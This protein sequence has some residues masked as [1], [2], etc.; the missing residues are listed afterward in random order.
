MSSQESISALFKTNFRTD[1][2][3]D[4][5]E[6]LMFSFIGATCGLAG[7]AYI[8]FHRQIVQFFRK[9]KRISGFLQQN[10]FVYPIFVTL[11]ITTVT[12]PPFIGKYTAS[13][14]S[15]H[16]TIEHLFSNRTWSLGNQDLVSKKILDQWTTPDTNFHLHLVLYILMLFWTSAL[17]ST[18]PIPSGLFIP[19]LKMGA[20]YGRLLGELMHSAFPDGIKYGEYVHPASIVPGS[21]A[22]VGAAAFSGA[23]TH[24]I[25]T[26]V[27]LFEMTGQIVHIIP[28]ILGVLIANAVCQSLQPS[29]YDSIIEIKK[30]P[31]LPPIASSNSV[32]HKILVKDFMNT[33][34]AYVWKEKCT[35]ADLKLLLATHKKIISFPLVESQQSMKL[36]GSVPRPDLLKLLYLHLGRERRLQEVCRRNS[37]TLQPIGL[38]EIVQNVHQSAQIKKDINSA[39][40]TLNVVDDD[41]DDEDGDASR[42]KRDSVDRGIEFSGIGRLDECDVTSTSTPTSLNSNESLKT[43]DKS[44][45]SPNQ[46]KLHLPP[47]PTNAGDQNWPRD[48]TKA[49]L[50]VEASMPANY[51]STTVEL[52]QNTHSPSLIQGESL[53]IGAATTTNESINSKHENDA[54]DGDNIANANVDDDEDNDSNDSNDN[55]VGQSNIAKMIN[56]YNRG[57]SMDDEQLNK[58]IQ[59]IQNQLAAVNETPEIVIVLPIELSQ[60]IDRQFVQQDTT[61]QTEIS[62]SNSSLKPPKLSHGEFRASRPLS[63]VSELKPVSS[64]NHVHPPSSPSLSGRPTKSILKSSSTS[65]SFTNMYKRNISS[66]SFSSTI[67]NLDGKQVGSDQQHNN[68]NNPNNQISIMI[69]GG[70]NLTLGDQTNPP[71]LAPARQRRKVRLP[72]LRVVDMTPEE[73][74]QWEKE[75][76]SAYIDLSKC[77]IDEAPF[78]LVEQTS[79]YRVHTLFSMLGLNHAYVTSFGRLVGIVALKDIR[80]AIEKVLQEK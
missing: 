78:Q 64:F 29:I 72:R 55:E 58:S 57:S 48:S 14:L 47:V 52:E 45:G 1:Y 51:G 80:F 19:V 66:Q 4:P 7:A 16:T 24:T 35:Y 18:I 5:I 22:V 40:N 75:Q 32:S 17:A 3:F 39:I 77:Q 30:L 10:R 8:K 49:R 59:E 15:T 13:T 73:Q 53:L 54:N 38:Y 43:D 71:E 46:F 60:P 42:F 50:I 79:L 28:V 6:L 36:L 11:I 27:I 56:H 65:A 34:L 76:L 70:S 31:Y 21:Y 44:D 62:L 23:V 26:S 12:F 37:D 63:S 67:S 2:P 74:E 20:A 61:K 68:S 41:D 33:N 9:H 25:S 69:G